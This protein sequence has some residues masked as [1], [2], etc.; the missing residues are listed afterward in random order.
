MPIIV[1]KDGVDVFR[2]RIET[3]WGTTIPQI[4]NANW[5]GVM[6]D[7]LLMQH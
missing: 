2:G 7:D 6:W 4:D 3:Q 5:Y 1:G